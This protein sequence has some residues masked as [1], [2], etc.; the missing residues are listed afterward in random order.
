VHFGFKQER[1]KRDSVCVSTCVRVPYLDDSEGPMRESE[2]RE[3][4]V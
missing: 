3:R 2:R 1:G 4:E